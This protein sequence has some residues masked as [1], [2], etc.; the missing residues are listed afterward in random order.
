M[1]RY[2]QDIKLIARYVILAYLMY[3]CWY[4]LQ[5]D[6][7]QMLKDLPDIAAGVIIGSPYGALTLVLK[8]HFGTKIE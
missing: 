8:Y 2:R 1:V 6:M 7:I 3:L 5:P 4:V